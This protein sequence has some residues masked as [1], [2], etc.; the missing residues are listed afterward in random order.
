MKV[1]YEF[2]GV[3][4]AGKTTLIRTLKEK[5]SHFDS[6][7]DLTDFSC[8]SATDILSLNPRFSSYA[9]MQL[10]A[11]C[12]KLFLL[13]YE[14][15]FYNCVKAVLRSA[16]LRRSDLNCVLLWEGEYHLMSLL[17][18]GNSITDDQLLIPYLMHS[19]CHH[20]IPVFVEVSPAVSFG[21]IKQ[22][23]TDRSNIRFTDFDQVRIKAQI[24]RTIKNQ[25]RLKKVFDKNNIFYRTI[26]NSDERQA[27][28]V[29]I[30]LVGDFVKRTQ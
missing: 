28:S 8:L 22:D 16:I 19:K 17:K 30:D 5:L 4:G 15:G 10:G 20:V 2:I 7:K 9:V 26:N 12:S 11:I 14:S 27:C 6:V 29:A 21:R 23:F 24:M 13:N 18:W 1:C 3:W 25:E